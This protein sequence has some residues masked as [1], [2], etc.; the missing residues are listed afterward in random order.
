MPRL[1]PYNKLIKDIKSVD[2]GKLHSIRETLCD[3]LDE[4]E[5]VD[6]VYRNIK[7][8]VLHLCQVLFNVL[9]VV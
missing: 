1:L 8:M 4:S 5:N 2:I 6:G 7:E 3:G 9:K